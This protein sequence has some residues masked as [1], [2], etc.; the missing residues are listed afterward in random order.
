M[1]AR[2]RRTA[3]GFAVIGAAPSR[4][5]RPVSRHRRRRRSRRRVGCGAA[6]LACDPP[7]RTSSARSTIRYFPLEPGT[8]FHYVGVSGEAPQTD[9]MVVTHQTKRILGVICTVVRDT[10]SEHGQAVERTFDWYAQDK[11]GNVWY[12]G[13]DSLELQNGHF[14]RATTRGSPESMARSPESS[15]GA[16]RGRATSTGRS[17]TRPVGRST[18]HAFLERARS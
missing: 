15:C 9:D 10:V 7:E 11:Q 2:L 18:R 16:I 6:L 12:M 5:S 1:T 13:E 4:H 14:V 8:A 17:T 3:L